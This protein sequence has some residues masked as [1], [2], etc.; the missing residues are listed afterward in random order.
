MFGATLCN[1]CSLP[2]IPLCFSCNSFDLFN[3]V[4]E[5]AE[6]MHSISSL[7]CKCI[8]RLL[9][10]KSSVQGRL[11]GYGSFGEL[12]SGAVFA[13]RA[14]DLRLYSSVSLLA[15]WIL[16][17]LEAVHGEA[18]RNNEKHKINNGPERCQL[19]QLLIIGTELIPGSGVWAPQWGPCVMFCGLSASPAFH[20]LPSTIPVSFY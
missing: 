16:L 4:I 19:P 1:H 3:T 2:F 10:L 8:L 12:A 13:G 14:W 11:L 6:N 7:S 20:F 18:L 17:R 5:V 9:G 15:A